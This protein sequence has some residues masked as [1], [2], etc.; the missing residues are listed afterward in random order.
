MGTA[1]HSNLALA[2]DRNPAWTLPDPVDDC[3]T[4]AEAFAGLAQCNS[5]LNM[6]GAKPKKKKRPVLLLDP[7]EAANA[8]SELAMTAAQD[9]ADPERAAAR[10][11]ALALSTGVEASDYADTGNA[12]DEWAARGPTP[13]SALPAEEASGTSHADPAPIETSP[14]RPAAIDPA[15]LAPKPSKPS[16]GLETARRVSPASN[17]TGQQ[18]TVEATPAPIARE[19]APRPQERFVPA[20]E[21]RVAVAPEPPPPQPRPAHARTNRFVEVPFEAE[22]PAQ[23]EQVPASSRTPEPERNALRRNLQERPSRSE[24]AVPSFSGLLARL[25]AAIE[26][27]TGRR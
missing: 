18:R 5:L 23:V 9:F 17:A 6:G 3:E 15:P 10:Q 21:A 14:N 2:G 4:E 1:D 13:L 7:Q 19:P 26:R 22:L 12:V 27:F 11:P 24:P 8:H 25:R 20:P 16:E